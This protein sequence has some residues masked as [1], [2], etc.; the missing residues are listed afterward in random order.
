MTP[1]FEGNPLTQS[2]GA[3]HSVNFVILACTVLIQ[4]SS[5]TD[6]RTDKRTDAQAMAKTRKAFCHHALKTYIFFSV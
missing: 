6:K 3:A 4:Y 5:V 1:S 2:F